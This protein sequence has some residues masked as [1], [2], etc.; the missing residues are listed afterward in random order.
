M[1]LNGRKPKSDARRTTAAVADSG[2]SVFFARLA[3]TSVVP[4][5]V[6]SPSQA[7]MTGAGGRA[8]LFTQGERYVDWK[9]CHTCWPLTSSGECAG[10]RSKGTEHIARCTWFRATSSLTSGAT[11]EARGPLHIAGCSMRTRSPHC[12][13][14]MSSPWLRGTSVIAARTA[15]TLG[16]RAFQATSLREAQHLVATSHQDQERLAFFHTLLARPIRPTSCESYGIA[17]GRAL[18][19]PTLKTLSDIAPQGT[20][21][22][23]RRASVGDGVEAKHFRPTGRW[24]EQYGKATRLQLGSFNQAPLPRRLVVRRRLR[25]A[26]LVSGLPARRTFF[27][28]ARFARARRPNWRGD[29]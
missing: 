14:C 5:Q 20:W 2:S 3:G 15:E 27:R 22:R 10:E 12:L 19:F 28:Q 25:R 24:Y 29:F 1:L 26:V 7:N 17:G 16:G 11:T 13:D 21:S 8:F 6:R 9:C 18:L 23:V 4:S